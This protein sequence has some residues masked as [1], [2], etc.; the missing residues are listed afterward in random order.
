MKPVLILYATREGHT[1]RVADRLARTV[2]SHGLSADT[3]DAAHVHEGFELG[4]YGAAIVCASVHGGKHE[5]EILEF[6]KRHVPE[7]HEIPTTFVSVSLSEAGAE[8]TGA[9]PERRAKAAADVQ[10]M[11]DLFLKETGW[12]PTFIRPVAGA[13]VYTKYNFLLRFVMK[14]IARKAGA[15]TDTSKDYEYTDWEG[16]DHFIAELTS[17]IHAEAPA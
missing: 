7:L 2:K 13:L 9:P 11:I 12:R 16:L 4:D 15:G 17:A 10:K 6:V 5:P 8:D 3:I 14:R 1:H